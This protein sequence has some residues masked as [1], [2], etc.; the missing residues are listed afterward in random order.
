M[1]QVKTSQWQMHSAVS[2]NE[3]TEIKDL[4]MNT[5]YSYLG[6]ELSPSTKQHSRTRHLSYLFNTFWNIDQNLAENYQRS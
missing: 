6:Y 4:D 2:P 5:P 1:F 3:K